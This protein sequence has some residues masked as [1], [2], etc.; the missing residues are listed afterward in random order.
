VR[1]S[2]VTLAL[3]FV[4]V[5]AA[6]LL[7]LACDLDPT[8]ADMATNSGNNGD[9]GAW[10]MPTFE[11]TVGGVHF[12]PGAPDVGS[13]AQLVNTYDSFTGRRQSSSFAVRASSAETGATCN[14]AV[15]RQ[16]D[17]IASI[18]VGAYQLQATSFG[19]TPD[20]VVVPL[21]SESVTIPQGT[22]SCS[23]S[24]CNGAALVIIEADT[25]HVLGY[26]AGTYQAS[27]GSASHS[28]VCSFWVKWSDLRQ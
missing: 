11:V 23:G 8:R 6:A 19:R 24:A 1:S 2:P 14:V 21:G 10:K 13:A 5:V 7:V 4:P 28:V 3:R 12:G 17:D 16:G 18:N 26:I 15:F 20:G 9:G 22:W 27:T 25:A